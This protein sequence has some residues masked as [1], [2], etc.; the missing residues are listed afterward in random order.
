MNVVRVDGREKRK[1]Q[2]YQLID[3]E[4]SYSIHLDKGIK[5]SAYTRFPNSPSL[6]VA[7]RLLRNT[8][9]EKRG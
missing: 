8:M 6:L 5:Y 1:H 3:N 4:F 2:I 9:L 7:L